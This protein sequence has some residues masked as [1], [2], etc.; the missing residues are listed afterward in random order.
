VSPTPLVWLVA[1]CSLE[2]RLMQERRGNR[3]RSY[4]ELPHV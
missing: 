2:E 4:Q 1:N 3:L